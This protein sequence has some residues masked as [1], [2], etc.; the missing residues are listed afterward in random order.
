MG[1]GAE[2][3][4]GNAL[5]EITLA[6][7]TSLA[8]ASA[9]AFVFMELPLLG[10]ALEPHRRTRLNK[11]LSLPLVLCMAGLIA[12]ATHLGNPANAL[13]VARGI[14]RSPLS[15]EVSAAV[16]F[17][18]CAAVVWLLGFS[19]KDRGG[20][21]RTLMLLAIPLAAAFI[22]MSALSYSVETIAAWN[23]PYTPASIAVGAFVLSPAIASV[24]FA[25]AGGDRLAAKSGVPLVAVSAAAAIVLFAVYALQ[26]V[27]LEHLGNF[28]YAAVD[29]VPHYGLMLAVYG[30]L[31]TAGVVVLALSFRARAAH[32]LGMRITAAALLFAALFIM[33]F[34]FYLMHLTVGVGM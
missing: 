34:A 31:S 3:A 17:L 6:L 28:M 20:L 13:Y 24:G 15:N 4:F 25:A 27:S 18:A 2:L 19:L 14:G 33:R 8:P 29:V 7:F 22:G 21:Q 9:L 26:G 10:G 5:G 11:A 12:S 23:T 16:V 32:P 30:A 1:S